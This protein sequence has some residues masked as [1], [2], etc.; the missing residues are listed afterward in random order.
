LSG[1]SFRNIKQRVKT[2]KGRKISSTKWL[3]R[4]FNDQYVLKAKQKGYR[5]RA[6]FKL[7]EI[8]DKFSVFKGVKKVVDLGCAPGGWLQVAAE[9]VKDSSKLIGVDLQDVQPIESCHIL[10]ADFTDE[11]TAAAITEILDGKADLIM[12]DMAANACGEPA[13]DHLRVVY[14]VELALDFAYQNLNKGGNFIAKMLKGG[15]ETKLIAEIRKRF[16]SV[17]YF[18]PDASYDDSSEVYIVA[19]GFK[20]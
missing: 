19:L 5:S 15:E 6:A 18:K 14:L 20:G 7:T 9:R 11:S 13:V 16:K 10:K 2:A 4:H 17:R 12:S 8:D 3:E 1:K